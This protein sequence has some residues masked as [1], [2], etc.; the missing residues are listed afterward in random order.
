MEAIQQV[1]GSLVKSRASNQFFL[2]TIRQVLE[3]SARLKQ[4][5]LKAE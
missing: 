4:Q 1:A 3:D 2:A 5:P